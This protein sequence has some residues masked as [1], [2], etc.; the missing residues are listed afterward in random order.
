MIP[1]LTSIIVPTYDRAN[2]LPQAVESIL[3]QTYSSIEVIIVDDGSPGNGAR[4][5]E[6][7]KPY[8]SATWP[9]VTYVYQEHRGV[10]EAINRGLSLAQGEYIQRLDDD[11]RLL[12]DKIAR[13]VKVFQ[14]KPNVGL[15]ATGYY[16]IDAKGTRTRVGRPCPCPSPARFLN[17]LMRCVSVQAGVMVRSLVHRTVGT[18]RQEL[19][20]EDYEMWIRISKAFDIETIDDPLAEYRRHSGNAT[21]QSNQMNVERDMFTFISEHLNETPLHVLVPNLQSSPAYAYALRAAVYLL[22]NGKYVKTISQAKEELEQGLQLL[23]DD[24]LLSLWK[25]MMA[26]YGE[27]SLRPAPWEDNL[28][29]PYRTKADE[30]YRLVRERKRLSAEEIDPSTPEAVAFRQQLS[31]F[32][33]ALTRETFRKATRQKD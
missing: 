7:L 17:M 16:N 32:R 6:V 12:P 24:P 19:I 33:S 11:D 1:G 29:Q 23:P 20:G 30:L 22:R 18:Y 21:D 28:P 2:Y 8:L 5:K 9:K 15:V 27:E 3:A 26:V 25:G 14:A 4:T 10:A 13:T 31:T